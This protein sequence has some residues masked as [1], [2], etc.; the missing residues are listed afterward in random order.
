MKILSLL[1]IRGIP[2][3][4]IL[5]VKT[6]KADGQKT[7]DREGSASIFPSPTSQ[8]RQPE[9]GAG[10]TQSVDRAHNTYATLE[11]KRAGTRHAM[12]L[13]Q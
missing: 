7:R 9:R 12:E 10:F 6:D 5:P 1:E 2:N 4:F 3:C 11:K 8:D 13:W